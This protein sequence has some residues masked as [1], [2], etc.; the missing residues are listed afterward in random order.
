MQLVRR[1]GARGHADFGWLDTRHTFS[2]GQYHDPAWMGFGPLRVIN[3]DRIAPGGGFPAHPHRD[4]EIITYVV[5]GALAH[6]DS[7]GNGSVISPGEVQHMSAGRGIRHSEFNASDSAPV[8]LLQIWIE[9]AEPGLEPGYQQ[10]RFDDTELAGRLRLV[11]SPDGRDGSIRI[12]QDADVSA[13]RF[14]AGDGT[15]VETPPGRRQWVQV[16]EGTLEA[17]GTPLEAGDGLGLDDA[18]T[19][20]LESPSGS[21][22]LLFDLPS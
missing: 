11:A 4:M 18:G 15:V 9:P 22:F 5:E 7:L 1:S 6:R 20:R 12:H 3:E 19:L 21:H 2:F 10:V 17:N 14:A 8:W 13:A 16:I